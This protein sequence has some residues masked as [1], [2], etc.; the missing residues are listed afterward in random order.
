MA[1]AYSAG[2]NSTN[3]LDRKSKM[4]SF[5]LSPDEYRRLRDACSLHGARNVSELARAAMQNLIEGKDIAVPL[6]EQVHQ[7]RE[8]VS[9]LSS[10][11]ERISRQVDSPAS[12]ND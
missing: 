5:R 11:V 8:R 10:E 12:A 1:V 3:M 7:L 9:V 2:P 6:P 4:I